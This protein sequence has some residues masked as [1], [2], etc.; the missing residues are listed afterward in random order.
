M[1]QIAAV[2][3]LALWLAGHIF[4]FAD[5]WLNILPVAAI[6]LFVIAQLRKRV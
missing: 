2:A 1:L 3:L 5:G 4:H 6:I